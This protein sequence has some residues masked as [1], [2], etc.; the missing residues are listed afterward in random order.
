MLCCA[1]VLLLLVNRPSPTHFGR[2]FVLYLYHSRTFDYKQVK[3]WSKKVPGKDIFGLDKVFFPINVSRMHWVCVVAFI[4]EKRI[5]FYDSF[6]S[7][8]THYLEIIFRY[9]Q[10]EHWDKKK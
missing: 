1:C 10:E 5:Q 9:L 2:H 4:Q 6:G 3:R 8:G 7:P